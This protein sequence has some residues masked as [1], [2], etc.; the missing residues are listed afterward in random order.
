MQLEDKNKEKETVEEKRLIECRNE[1]NLERDKLW[2]E[3][4]DERANHD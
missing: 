1:W 3:N 2:L 4:A